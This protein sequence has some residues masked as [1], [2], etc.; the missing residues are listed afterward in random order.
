MKIQEVIDWYFFKN[1]LEFLCV[2]RETHD[3]NGTL[4]Q[5]QVAA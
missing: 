1:L 4:S 2:K 5:Y 3:N